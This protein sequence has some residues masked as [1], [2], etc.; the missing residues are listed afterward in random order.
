MDEDNIIEELSLTVFV[1][2]CQGDSGGPLVC[3]RHNKWVQY[4]I[5]SFSTADNPADVP[6]IFTRVSAYV[7]WIKL[8][9]SAN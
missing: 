5:A 3:R 8:I 4:G 2:R 6:G 7:D 1:L 9:M